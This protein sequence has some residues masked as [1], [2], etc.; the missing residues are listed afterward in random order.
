ML[1]TDVQLYK[2]FKKAKKKSSMSM[3]MFRIEIRRSLLKKVFHADL[4]KDIKE[5]GNP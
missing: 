5:W 1:T 2:S 3:S 4:D